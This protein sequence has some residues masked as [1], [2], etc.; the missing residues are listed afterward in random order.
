M[1]IRLTMQKVIAKMEK[2]PEKELT[3]RKDQEEKEPTKEKAHG[4]R[5]KLAV[6]RQV[7]QSERK[8][9]G[10]EWLRQQVSGRW[11]SMHEVWEE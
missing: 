6:E 11:C 8:L 9:Y 3:D 10:I 1:L 7:N 2:V 4:T 5:F